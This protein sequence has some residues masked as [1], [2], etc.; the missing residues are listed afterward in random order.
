MVINLLPAK[1][2]QQSRRDYCY[3]LGALASLLLMVVFGAG[4]IIE[5]TR[6][7]SARVQTNSWISDQAQT[8]DAGELALRQEAIQVVARTNRQ[9]AVL[10]PL[11]SEQLPPS[12]VIGLLLSTRPAGVKLQAINYSPRPAGAVV[13]LTGVA[14]ARSQL[15]AWEEKIERLSGV[16][17]VSSPLSN[18]VRDQDA[19]FSLEIE[20]A[21]E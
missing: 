15:L 8:A 14:G 12:A 17:R 11:S 5:L 13:G 2:K 19:A 7:V 20:F 21:F 16:S 4:I 18:L 1:I 6:G 9:L 10:Q 3:R